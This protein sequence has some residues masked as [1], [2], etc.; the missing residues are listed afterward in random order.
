MIRK[1]LFINVNKSKKL[2]SDNTIEH[3]RGTDGLPAK[4]HYDLDGI[5][6]RAS[7]AVPHL[8]ASTL[9]ISSKHSKRFLLQIYSSFK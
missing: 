1:H 2:F 6:H 3:A 8:A 4:C 7:V 5:H 9:C